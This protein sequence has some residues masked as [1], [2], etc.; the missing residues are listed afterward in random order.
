MGHSFMRIALGQINTTI[1][2]LAGNAAKVAEFAMRAAGRGADL[3]AFPELAI[4]GYPPRD[5]IERPA[6][7]T[8]ARAELERLAAAI[9]GVAITVVVGTVLPA[10]AESGK[11]AQ[12]AAVVLRNG[13]EVFRQVKMLLPTY[14]VFDE[15]R[16]FQAGTGQQPLKLDGSQ[17]LGITV[18]EDAW[19]DKHYWRRPLYSR[20]PVDELV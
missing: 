17:P 9:E 16:Y 13:R 18:C 19:K 5:L 10:L 14:D 2:D 7:V 12:N 11:Q 15:T 8:R 1:G 20:D 4:C 6:F 3:I